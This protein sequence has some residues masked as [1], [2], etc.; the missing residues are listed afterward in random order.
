MRI[1]LIADSPTFPG[2]WESVLAKARLADELGFASI[3]LGEAWG[4]E[5]FT[6]LADLVRATTRIEIG[7]GVANVFSR[8]P[9]VIASAAATLDERSGGRV[10]LGLGT[11]GPQVIEHWHGV[12]FARPLRRLR[13]YVEIVDLILRREKLVYYGEIYS[14]ERGFTLRFNPLRDH[15]PIYIAALG[16]KSIDQ[17]GEIADGVLPI[18]WPAADYP[19]LRARLDRAS[20]RVGRPPGSVRIAPYLTAE[21]ILD[22]AEREAARQRARGPL[23][24]YVGRMGTFYA[25]MLRR[26]G[27]ARDVE[28][29]STGWATGRS[30]AQNAVSDGLLDATAL[31]GTPSEIAD[32]LSELQA[33]GVDEPLLSMPSGPLDAAAPKLEALAP[34]PLP[35]HGDLTKRW[36]YGRILV[37][38][39]PP[40]S[41]FSIRGSP[42]NWS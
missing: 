22:E 26:H 39:L 11:S 29:I 27:F 5:L 10:L 9:A 17:A 25:E 40:R 28:K 7:A 33:L 18:Y 24:F 14:L 20:A 1:G 13:E 3:W 41:P 21:I 34:S 6:S 8:S 19:A 12:P 30:A 36:G 2:D 4:Y 32:R 16:P 15:L 35:L 23:A 38:D 37:A 31:V 42:R